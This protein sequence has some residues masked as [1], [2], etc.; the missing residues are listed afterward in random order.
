M[1][2]EGPFGVSLDVLSGRWSL[3]GDSSVNYMM[4][5]RPLT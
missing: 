5:I 3:S 1:A 2:V 4:T